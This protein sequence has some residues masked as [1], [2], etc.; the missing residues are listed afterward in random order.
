MKNRD[1]LYPF[2]CFK[3]GNLAFVHRLSGDDQLRIVDFNSL[4]WRVHSCFKADK[5]SFTTNPHIK[6]LQALDRNSQR[7]PFVHRILPS[8][9][10]QRKYSAGIVISL[11]SSADKDQYFNV[12]TPENNVIEIKSAEK[13]QP[14]NC[15]LVIDLTQQVR[16]GKGKF[17]V[18]KI[19]EYT[20][21]DFLHNSKTSVEDIYQVKVS[22]TQPEQLETFVDRLLKVFIGQG[23]APLSILPLETSQSKKD[24][25]HHRQIT[26]PPNSDF[27]SAIGKLNVPDFIELS[28]KQIKLPNAENVRMVDIKQE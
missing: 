2:Y 22:S 18:K 11:P 14:K 19:T 6:L 4:Q 23:I 1:L 25:T 10:K 20:V 15:G 13:K 3:C 9:P 12:L 27:Y 28:A 5:I 16:I 17:R 26:I 8:I 7:L 21:P 24:R